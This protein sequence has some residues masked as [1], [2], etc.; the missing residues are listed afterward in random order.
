[1]WGKAGIL[2]GVLLVWCACASALDPSL[3]ISQFRHTAWTFGNG[4]S[5]GNIFAVAQTSD[6]YFW[7]GGE[8]GLFRF[9]GVRAVPWQP[10]PGQ[11][12]PDR[13]VFKLLGARDGTLWIATFEGLVTWDGTRLIR[14]P[15]FDRRKVQSL[16]EDHEGTVWA[17]TRSS[18]SRFARLCAMR[19]GITQCFGDDG[20][21][22]RFVTAVY[23]DPASTLWVSAE[24]GLWQWKPGA[25]QRRSTESRDISAMADSENGR[26]LL[27]IYGGGLLQLAGEKLKA[28]SIPGSDSNRPL[29][30]PDVNANELLRDRDGGLW[31]GTVEHGLIHVG[32]GRS[33][34]FVKSD[35]LSGDV[36]LSLFEDREGNVWV[37]TT[38]GLDR[39]SEYAVTTV[40]FKQ[41]L[42]SDAV[43]SVLADTDGSVWIG[44]HEGLT[45][46]WNG[47]IFN[48]RKASGLP[49]DRIEA[50]YQDDRGRL[51]VFA[52]HELAY[53]DGQRFVALRNTVPSEE[54]YS[55]TGDER[56]NLWLAGNKG[57]SHLRDGRLVEHFPWP[58]LGH[59]E[60]AKDLVADQGGV[61]ISFWKDGA[62]LYFKDGRARA[63]YTAGDGLGKGRIAGLRLGRDGALW[64]ATDEGGLSRIK[65]G[66]I[67]T[68]AS[69]NGLPCDMIHWAIEDSDGSLWLYT[70]CGLV[71][72]APSELR[73]WI[74]DPQ[75][76][77]ATS[78]LDAA[79]GVRLRAVSASSYGPPV[80]RSTDGKLWF[81][82][83]E[84]IQIVNPRHLAYN[85]LPP[86]V[87]IEQVTA[88]DKSY[89][90]T[91]GLRLPPHVRNLSID[92]TAV[93]MVAPEKVRFRYKLEGVDSDW[94]E[95]SND[96]EVQY[97]NLA[98]KPYR[99]RLL[100]ANNSGVWNET[101]D[102]LDFSIAPAWYQTNWFLALCAMF[103]VT[104]LWAA[105]KWRTRQL[106]HQFEMT[107]EARV[108]ERTRI[109]RELH[110]TLLQSFHALLLR[111]GVVD[112]LLPDRAQEAKKELREAMDQAGEA[113]TEG[114][115]AVQALRLS[116]IETNDLVRA[117]Q[118]IGQALAANDPSRPSPCFEMRVEGGPREL[119]PL[120]RDEVYRVAA[121]ALRN[122][123]RHAN[124]S[125]IEAE[126][127]YGDKQ[128][129]I[130]VRDDG[131][132]IDPTVLSGGRG[133]HYGLPGMRERAEV[134]GGKLA[135]WSELETGTEVELTIPAANAYAAAPRSSW[136]SQRFSRK[137]SD[138]QE[139]KIE[140]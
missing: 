67:T 65:D 14:H 58:A 92:Y 27:A 84:G 3:E 117:I 83:G 26:T 99:F 120:L 137:G 102:T 71:R 118:N 34:A 35:G 85:P 107:L 124:A 47:Q 15:E 79:D 90:P 98:P 44:T 132:G 123:F 76:R 129:R 70:A 73:A 62:V 1:M 37:S 121:E 105:H 109:A 126:I 19:G 2:F 51:W 52:G 104:L 16:I 139:T 115:D 128:F 68:L 133:G 88:D 36:V 6:G 108:S 74:A 87:H 130:R 138:V 9:D 91:N 53:F 56:D 103:L 93:S 48:Y 24:S 75:Y 43:A 42:A 33:D 77:V 41:G 28:Y 96:R 69:R 54:V 39:F 119:R 72:I 10:P 7:L 81:V 135:V 38:G 40:S 86:P 31:I 114:R 11:Q 136:W 17:A 97:T 111:F 29:P 122:A 80:A 30:D 112:R 12:L 21:L 82:T 116:T 22:G 125:R 100:A 94:R 78:V 32:H 61:W 127:R 4:F 57:L 13:F 110:D 101:G 46:W 60:Q 140:S 106:Q 66:R 5:V 134:V 55:I 20:V 50:L 95:V 8:F 113:I 18:E 45:R 89:G 64:A 25:P 63:S 59:D 49:D 131:K 23:E